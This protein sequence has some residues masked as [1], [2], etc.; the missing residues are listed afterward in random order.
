MLAEKLNFRNYFPVTLIKSFSCP[1]KNKQTKED[2]QLQN[3]DL[4]V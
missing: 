3:T 4:E 1:K 2:L